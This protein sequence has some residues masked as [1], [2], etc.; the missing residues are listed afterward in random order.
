M[1]DKSAGMTKECA[2]GT[3]W[4]QCTTNAGQ[5]NVVCSNGS[6]QSSTGWISA[7]VPEGPL[8]R[9][10]LAGK[11]CE[12]CQSRCDG[13]PVASIDQAYDESNSS[14]GETDWLLQCCCQV[15]MLAS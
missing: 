5:S 7:Q 4:S 3:I 12:L 1:Q 14:F 10:V 2:T 9:G 8:D 15:F 6:K 11:G 13:A